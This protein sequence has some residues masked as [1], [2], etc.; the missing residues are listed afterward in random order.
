MRARVCGERTVGVD[1]TDSKGA[2]SQ[3]ALPRVS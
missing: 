2:N 1:S 3:N